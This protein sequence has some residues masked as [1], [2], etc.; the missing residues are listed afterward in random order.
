MSE[1]ASLSEYSNNGKMRT[2]EQALKDTLADIGKRGAFEKGK[3]I[4]IIG[5]DES[6]E[7][8]FISW[9]QAGMKM[10]ECLALLEVAKGRFLSEMGFL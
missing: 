10:S 6:E 5:L 1:I 7:Q 2:P 9:A 3:K 8:Y 4:L